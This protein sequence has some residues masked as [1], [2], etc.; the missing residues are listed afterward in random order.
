LIGVGIALSL[1]AQ[2]ADATIVV[3]IREQRELIVGADAL[4]QR[5]KDPTNRITVCKIHRVDDRT[6]FSLTGVTE[7]VPSGF[8]V[9]PFVRQTLATTGVSTVN[10]KR[11]FDHI[12]G[13]ALAREMRPAPEAIYRLNLDRGALAEVIVFR[14]LPDG[15]PEIDQR[16]YALPSHG[17]RGSMRVFTRTCPPECAIGETMIAAYG[18]IPAVRVVTAKWNADAQFF[19]R[20]RPHGLADAIHE[21]IDG[22]IAAMPNECAPPVSILRLTNAGPTWVEPGHCASTSD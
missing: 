6:F 22:A 18:W 7:F 11:R 3:A 12:V 15:T 4:S 8:Q 10:A 9:A 13:K 14:I 5:Q 20:P 19:A 16:T 21:L 17:R 1:L 2:G